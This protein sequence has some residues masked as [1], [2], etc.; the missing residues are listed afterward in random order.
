MHVI[1]L[2]VGAALALVA[3]LVGG[4][5][6][7]VLLSPV[8]AQIITEENMET[9]ACRDSGTCKEWRVVFAISAAFSFA[10][11]V[12]TLIMTIVVVLGMHQLLALAISAFI[13]CL[14]SMSLA[15]VASAYMTYPRSAAISSAV[16]MFL[17][18]IF[19]LVVVAVPGAVLSWH[20]IFRLNP[21]TKNTKDGDDD[22]R[23]SENHNNGS[24]QNSTRYRGPT[25]K[26]GED[27]KEYCFS[28]ILITRSFDLRI[29]QC[30]T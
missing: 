1:P 6:L 3:A 30:R 26:V 13:L 8:W 14:D 16:I 19:T 28:R 24:S 4:G 7:A 25:G 10:M 2:Q 9:G 27:G 11:A 23:T 12:I 5:L 15:L 21:E 20:L 17:L 18:G 29:Q 22:Q